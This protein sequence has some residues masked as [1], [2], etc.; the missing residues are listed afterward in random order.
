MV[1]LSLRGRQKEKKEKKEKEGNFELR[2]K[3]SQ[4]NFIVNSIYICMYDMFYYYY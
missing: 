1:W 3:Q 2:E 4:G